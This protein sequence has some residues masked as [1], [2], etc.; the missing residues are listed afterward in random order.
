MNINSAEFVFLDFLF[1]TPRLRVRLVLSPASH[2]VAGQPSVLAFRVVAGFTHSPTHPFTRFFYLFPVN[3]LLFGRPVSNNTNLN[4]LLN[5][6][7]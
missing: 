1:P 3:F 2:G 4:Q 5:R 7:E 6:V